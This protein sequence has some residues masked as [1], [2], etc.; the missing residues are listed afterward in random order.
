ML[1]RVGAGRLLRGGYGGVVGLYE[2]VHA[3]PFVTEH[4]T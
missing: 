4:R 3:W 1:A 2:T